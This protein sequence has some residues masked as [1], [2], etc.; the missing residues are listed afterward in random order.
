MCQRSVEYDHT[1]ADKKNR[2][3]EINL[4]RKKKGETA[5]G[6]NFTI[7]HVRK[8]RCPP[9]PPHLQKNNFFAKKNVEKNLNPTPSPHKIQ[10]N[11]PEDSWGAKHSNELWKMRA[12][13][14]K[15]LR[16]KPNE[17]AR[18]MKNRRIGAASQNRKLSVF[19]K[20]SLPTLCFFVT[21][22]WL[23]CYLDW[24]EEIQ[25]WGNMWYPPPKKRGRKWL[26]EIYPSF[27]KK[28]NWIIM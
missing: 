19:E 1:L 8:N 13:E 3:K 9:L 7:R 21:C 17:S 28:P 6:A 15:K 5:M 2:W 24:D 14:K 22:M 10:I 20:L 25:E 16:K 18:Q 23:G 26:K 11:I 12:K 27:Q 4:K